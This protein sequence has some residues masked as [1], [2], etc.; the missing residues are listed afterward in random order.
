MKTLAAVTRSGY[1]ESIHQGYICVVDENGKVEYQ[2]GDIDTRIFFRSSAKPIQLIPFIHSGGAKAMDYSLKELAI[3]CASHTGEAQHQQTVL[4]ILERLG[5]DADALHCGVMSPYNPEENKRLIAKNEKPS[6][7]H[8]SCSG[9]HAAML[10]YCKF[11]DYDI[12]NYENPS[13][14]LQQEILETLSEFTDEAADSI[15]IG[16]D[17]CGLPIFMLPV[18]KIALSY[19]RITKYSQ[20]EKS[21]YFNTC[22]TIFEAMNEHPEMVAGTKEFCTELMKAT[23]GKLIA[24]IGAEAVYCLGIKDRNLGVCVKIADGGER[25]V[26]PVVMQLLLELNVLDSSEYQKLE[27]W[28]KFELKN[29]RDE[30]VG[31]ILPVFHQH[32]EVYPG[33]KIN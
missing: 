9:K 4:K 8:A 20:D 18:R 29:H 27:H 15:S 13:H 17:G 7:L 10:A 5:L 23:K 28:H 31:D 1:V 26:F 12:S 33:K 2:Q 16:T 22:R 21:K 14:P 3:A 11:K 19:A 25:A 32:D 24:K 30:H 6:T